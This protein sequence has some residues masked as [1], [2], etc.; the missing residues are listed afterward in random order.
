MA[1]IIRQANSSDKE[2]CLGLLQALSDATGST[3]NPQ[4]GQVY[5]AM[6]NGARGEILVADQAG[7][8][9]GM[10]SLS[11]NLA[12]RHGGE[13]CQLEELVVA[14]AAR[15]KNAGAALMQA[16]VAAAKQRGCAEFG[17]YLMATTEN[18]REF[19]EK[20]GFQAVGTEMRQ[21]FG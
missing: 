10:A 15:G 3:A 13:Y 17:L 5:E 14:H 21:T 6:I 20:F 18:N 1:I 7:Q 19:Y 11:Y 12:L 2:A 9:L 8:L 16:A 4:A